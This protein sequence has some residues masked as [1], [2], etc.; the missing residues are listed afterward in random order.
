MISVYGLTTLS[1]RR[2]YHEWVPR[3][4][5]VRVCPK[6]KSP[7]FDKPC[8]NEP[9][10]PTDELQKKYPN[11]ICLNNMGKEPWK[12]YRWC[13]ECTDYSEGVELDDEAALKRLN[14]T[15]CTACAPAPCSACFARPSVKGGLCEECL[16]KDES[17]E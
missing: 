10:D 6:C 5:E 13:E 14:E 17:H 2:C 3:K 16:S 11:L 12:A 8:R 15:P 4:R 7:Y 1:C 9:V